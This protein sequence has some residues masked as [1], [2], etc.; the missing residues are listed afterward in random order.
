MTCL[1]TGLMTTLLTPAR[2]AEPRIKP[3]MSTVCPFSSPLPSETASRG[4]QPWSSTSRAVPIRLARA[5]LSVEDRS[6]VLARGP[7]QS[8]TRTGRVRRGGESRLRTHHCLSVRR[9]LPA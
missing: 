5:A 9:S 1:A 6:D 8:R 3:W 7:A 4:P 2:E